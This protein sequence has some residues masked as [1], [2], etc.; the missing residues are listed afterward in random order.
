LPR[1]DRGRRHQ[2]LEQTRQP[3]RPADRPGGRVRGGLP[4]SDHDRRQRRAENLGWLLS[5]QPGREDEAEA[6]YREAITTGD[7]NARFNL[8]WLLSKQ[9]GR[10]AEAEAAYR[11]A[12]TTGDSDAWNNLG[13]LLS[14]QPGRDEE[15]EAAYAAFS[16]QASNLTSDDANSAPDVLLHTWSVDSRLEASP[17]AA[18]PGLQDR[19]AGADADA[20]CGPSPVPSAGGAPNSD[21]PADPRDDALI[22]KRTGMRCDLTPESKGHDK[23]QGDCGEG[24]LAANRSAC[25]S[26]PV[27][28]A[29]GSYI[30]QVK[31]LALAGIGLPFELV[32]TYNSGDPTVGALGRGSTHS[33]EISLSVRDGG[34]VVVSRGQSGQRLAFTRL[35]GGSYA[36][37]PNGR[38]TLVRTAGGYELSRRDQVRYRF[39]PSGRLTELV[40]RNSRRL[41]MGYDVGGRLEK[42]TDTVGRQVTLSYSDARLTQVTLAD[43]RKVSYAY[44][45]GL[46]SSVTD[47]RG[48]VTR[49]EYAGGR[50]SKAID[51]NNHPQITNVYGRGGRITSQSDALGKQTSFSWDANGR[52]ATVKDPRGQEWRDLY[53]SSY[54]LLRES[55]PLGQ[56]RSYAY[57]RDSNVI[58]AEDPR[59]HTTEMS[60]DRDANLLTRT[61]A[62]GNSEK[63]TYNARNDP[64]TH[65]DARGLTTAYD[66]DG[67]G[68]LV[69]VTQPGGVVTALGRDP[70]G[71]GLLKSVTDPRG[72]TE[73]YDHDGQGNLS[74]LTSP[75]G[76]SSALVSCHSCWGG[77]LS[78]RSARS[79]GCWQVVQRPVQH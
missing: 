53:S 15:A 35:P 26:D 42:V 57:D 36:P 76:F 70:A 16:S 24:D 65:T 13:W 21:A 27:N 34:A 54:E 79:T 47:V 19:S 12:I 22:S 3:A 25:R 51:Q 64:L 10:E 31:D 58:A 44:A 52:A 7:T 6:A 72:K 43:A 66:Y 61:D 20:G 4:R 46:L 55:D 74:A 67:Q 23:P 30:A 39:D 75:K 50:L 69:K 2:R 29:T 45:G 41:V 9:P 1:G 40:D 18:D 8:G 78:G 59:G 77:R 11:E 5:K 68:N 73:R 32:R 63:F 17:G 14:E 49:Y 48:G 71:T 28:T 62:L 33:Y 37:T 38:A 60:Y 56:R